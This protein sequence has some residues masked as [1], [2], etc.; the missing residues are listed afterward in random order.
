M[1]TPRSQIGATNR[2]GGDIVILSGSSSFFFCRLPLHLSYLF[3]R[4]EE[5]STADRPHVSFRGFH[6]P[7]VLHFAFWKRSR[8]DTVAKLM[9]TREREL[10]S[11]RVS[12]HFLRYRIEKPTFFDPFSG[13]FILRYTHW[14]ELFTRERMSNVDPSRNGCTRKAKSEWSI[15]RL[16]NRRDS[17]ERERERDSLLHPGTRDHGFSSHRVLRGEESSKEEAKVKRRGRREG[18]RRVVALSRD[19]GSR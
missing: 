13:K 2:T 3:G 9:A 19:G 18:E 5:R 10:G 12:L 15:S 16:R 8:H 11:A 14:Q 17:Q 7:A 4:R 6:P 1:T